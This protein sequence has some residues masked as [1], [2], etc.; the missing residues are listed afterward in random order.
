MVVHRESDDLEA[1]AT[2]AY[3]SEPPDPA[4]PSRRLAESGRW[5]RALGT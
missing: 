1:T 4:V 3:A 5:I 2:F